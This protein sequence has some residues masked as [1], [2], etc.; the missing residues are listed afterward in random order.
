MTNKYVKNRISDKI[1]LTK[2][3]E[4]SVRGYYLT[5]CTHRL[6]IAFSLTVYGPEIDIQANV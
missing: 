5:H 4:I 6:K 1:I 3:D 2:K